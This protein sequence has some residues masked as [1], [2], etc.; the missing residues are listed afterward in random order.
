M[1]KYAVYVLSAYAIS[2]LVIGVM[3]L[4]TVLRARRWKAEARRR[5]QA[6]GKGGTQ[7]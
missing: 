2:A 3:I 5:E 4:D 1:G 7:A 6:L